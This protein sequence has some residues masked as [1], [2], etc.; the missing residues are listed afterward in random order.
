MH[1]RYSPDRSFESK[2]QGHK[3]H[4]VAP[5]IPTEIPKN[6]TE[7][8]NPIES[9]E[10]GLPIESGIVRARLISPPKIAL[11][12]AIPKD[13]KTE[14][15]D[16]I[17]NIPGWEGKN[18]E[19]TDEYEYVDYPEIPNETKLPENEI[20][21]KNLVPELTHHLFRAL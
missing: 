15:K 19:T 2:C 6:P 21:D 13:L 3:A 18:W 17:Y 5:L 8:Q 11:K 7:S 1:S 20:F 4:T 10:P 16:K 9:L 12:S 14:Q